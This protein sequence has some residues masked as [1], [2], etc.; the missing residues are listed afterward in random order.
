MVK[1]ASFASRV[2]AGIAGG[3]LESNRI[4]YTLRS[5]DVGVFGPGHQGRSVFGVDLLVAEVDR[6]AA[7][8][9][10]E[11]AGLVEPE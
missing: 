2:E 10:L 4:A 1:I 5:D 6:E 9:L 7:R 11:D 8:R 3:V